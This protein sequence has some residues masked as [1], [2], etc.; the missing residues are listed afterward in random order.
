MT[1][2]ENDEIKHQIYL[3]RYK[4]GEANKIVKLLDDANKKIIKELK[5]VDSVYSKARYEELNRLLKALSKELKENI[6]TSTDIDGIIEYELEKQ[7]KLFNVASK[8]VNVDFLY[9]SL[10]QVKKS[11]LFTPIVPSMTYQ[12]YLE[13]IQQGFY[14]QWDSA[15]RTGYL[16]SETTQKIIKD[17]MGSLTRPSQVLD[18]GTMTTLRN[19]VYRNTRTTLQAFASET[20]RAVYERDQEFISGYKFLATLDRRTCV[21]CGNYDG[22]IFKNLE[23][24]PAIPI[25]YN[26]R[27]VL[28]PII[29]GVDVIADERPEEWG[30]V[31]GTVTYKEWLESQPDFIQ[32]EILGERRYNMYK[33]GVSFDSFTEGFEILTLK[34]LRDKLN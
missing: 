20:R 31:K 6:D 34:E 10:E 14:N 17:V 9:P 27:C 23:D 4:T 30:T 19:S 11:A 16:T 21:I 28:V 33:S 3:E 25:H 1:Q 32:K 13:G 12:S 15:I 8:D 29:K 18:K 26:C 7:K 22:K 2:L 5:V 24:A